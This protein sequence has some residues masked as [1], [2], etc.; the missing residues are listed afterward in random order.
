MKGSEGLN[1]RGTLILHPETLRLG[2]YAAF[3]LMVLIST[4]ITVAVIDVE[5]EK[6]ALNRTYGYNNGG[7]TP[8]H[9]RTPRPVRPRSVRSR[10]DGAHP[11][12]RPSL[13][14]RLTPPAPLP[15]VPVAVCVMWDFSPAKEV[16]AII[17]PLA[18]YLFQAYLLV[19]LI[20]SYQSALA[21]EV[22]RWYLILTCV[23]TAITMLIIAEFHIVFIISPEVSVG[24]HTYPFIL[25]QVGL[26]LIATQNY[27][28][29]HL[30]GH[31]LFEASVGPVFATLLAT[32]YLV[33]FF[34]VTLIKI[35]IIG[36]I[37]NGRPVLDTTVSSGAS[38]AQA[39]DT[40]WVIFAVPIPM[41]IAAAQRHNTPSM[42]LQMRPLGENGWKALQP[43]DA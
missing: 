24:G 20:R 7:T 34:A 30:I 18:Q 22:P 8:V 4:I 2:A 14:V 43:L 40:L 39:A 11:H 19:C 3:I 10:C 26:L 13:R 27:I 32:M 29:N 9:V 1:D 33:C 12:A 5:Y 25:L 36:S 21:G 23:F 6:T 37:L 16:A 41:A 35:I 31:R 38:L 17:F 28:Y 42:I 15:A